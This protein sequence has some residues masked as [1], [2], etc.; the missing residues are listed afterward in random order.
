MRYAPGM[1]CYYSV[2]PLML[3]LFGAIGALTL[4][5]ALCRDHPFSGKV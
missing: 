4:V 5:L 3:W 1:R 2:I